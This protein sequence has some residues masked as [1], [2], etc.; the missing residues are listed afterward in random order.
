M[1]S[2]AMD[3]SHPS[4]S[5][6]ERGG[7]SEETAA[8]WSTE[9]AG[10]RGGDGRER[11]EDGEGDIHAEE[12]SRGQKA[13]TSACDQ[14]WVAS[15]PGAELERVESFS[16]GLL[17]RR[18][19]K[20]AAVAEFAATCAHEEFAHTMAG[21][22]SSSCFGFFLFRAKLLAYGPVQ[23]IAISFSFR[24]REFLFEPLE[25]GQSRPRELTF[26]HQ[27][28]SH[29]RHFSTQIRHSHGMTLHNTQSTNTHKAPTVSS[30]EWHELCVRI[31]R[32]LLLC[33]YLLHGHDSPRLLVATAPRGREGLFAARQLG[34]RS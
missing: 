28:R 5:L 18:M 15:A 33:A 3:D 34:A 8:G 16:F 26:V 31:D 13:K 4:A 20:L 11:K 10:A 27:L 22:R 2:P 32:S 14:R 23:R 24:F 19:E 29:H 30:R 25:L 9:D 7:G 12:Q 1:S 17:V 6:L 21:A